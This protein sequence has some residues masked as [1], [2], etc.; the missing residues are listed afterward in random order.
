MDQYNVI[1]L[2]SDIDTLNNDM[3]KWSCL[4]YERRMISDDNCRRMYGISNIDLYNRLKAAILSNKAPKDEEIIGNIISEGF[5][6]NNDDSYVQLEELWKINM[7]KELN[8]SPLIAII[9][10]MKLDNNLSVD[11]CIEVVQSLYNKY[12]LLN[13]KN[14]RFSNSYSLNLFGY[15]VP[16]M[17]EIIMNKLLNKSDEI[18]NNDTLICTGE[19]VSEKF[20]SP[21]ISNVDDMIISD[22]KIG[23]LKVKLDSVYENMKLSDKNIYNDI[24]NAIDDNMKYDFE[25]ILPKV[26]PWFTPDECN[27][28]ISCGNIEVTSENY[29]R[30]L[31]EK[32][33]LYNSANSIEEKISLEKDIVDL[34][35]NPSVP[36]NE[37]TIEFSRNK[38]CNWL[39]NHA[40]TIVDISKMKL[41]EVSLCESTSSMRKR[42]K[43]LD[44]YPVYIV[45]S[46]TETLFGKIIRKIKN[47]MFTHAGLCLD[48]DLRNILTFEFIQKKSNGFNLDSLED[49]INKTPRAL[50]SVMCVFV[51]K[52]TMLSL[53]KSINYFIQN[54]DK[55]KYNFGNL[56][57][58]LFNKEKSND[59]ANLSLV[60][61]QFVDTLLKMCNIDITNKSSN[62][63]IPQDFQNIN[64]PKVYKLYE[65]LA[66]EYNEK[67]IEELIYELFETKSRRTILYSK[68]I[69][70]LEENC[71]IK[72]F[73]CITENNKANEILNEINN[74][75]TPVA[76]IHERKAP[77][78]I[79]NDGNITIQLMKDLE[80]EYQEAHKLLTTYSEDN[81]EGI[82]EELARLFYLNS[83]IEKKLKKIDKDNKHYK[84][85]I[86]LRSR[87][88]N[89]FKKYLKVVL[90]KEPDFNFTEYY[91]KSKYY[92]GEI[93]IDASTIGSLGRILGKILRRKKDN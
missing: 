71:S 57:N 28:I 7:A 19:S 93:E 38:Y 9:Y 12:L 18:H 63:V 69:D 10:P 37:K 74:L 20:M 15:N 17:N 78:K 72:T 52:N 42:F 80:K 23:M 25:S 86:N 88:L 89:D 77:I 58:I 68:L 47:S 21:I 22:D 67:H 3:Y 92:D 35:W 36:L 70:E 73:D 60:C 84:E 33:K 46:Y 45:L 30:L 59:S 83:I 8:N 56:F 87:I 29:Y 39:R 11:E 53:K 66:K 90:K 41:N 44:L 55:T 1:Q 26:V 76:V 14:R 62:L 40:I 79:S 81:L 2:T 50:L 32:I 65:G 51:D 75:L 31:S 43:E 49:Y 13:E 61:S 6:I 34:G 64:N 48:S 27:N 16:N 5:E 54:K 82:K 4:P 85:L 91:Q 24:C